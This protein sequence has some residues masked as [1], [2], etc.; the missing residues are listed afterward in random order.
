MTVTTI[1][2]VNI[3]CWYKLTFP[4][5]WR[6]LWNGNAAFQQIV[7]KIGF[8]VKSLPR[9]RQE[10]SPGHD[11]SIIDFIVNMTFITPISIINTFFVKQNKKNIKCIYKLYKWIKIRPNLTLNKKWIIY[12]KVKKKQHNHT[13]QKKKSFLLLNLTDN[14]KKFKSDFIIRY[15]KRKT[16]WPLIKP[17]DALLLFYCHV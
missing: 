7:R 5:A 15:F 2:L 3:K 10:T 4:V 8:R 13:I 16:I 6:I 17:I 1:L 14:F 9:W 12:F 11:L